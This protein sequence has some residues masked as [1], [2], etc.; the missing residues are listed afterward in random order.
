MVNTTTIYLPEGEHCQFTK[1][2]ELSGDHFAAVNQ[3]YY[4]NGLE[5]YAIYRK[6][7]KHLGLSRMDGWAADA[8]ILGMKSQPAVW[9][10]DYESNCGDGEYLADFTNLI[11]GVTVSIRR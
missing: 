11:N 4:N 2:V 6:D 8:M 5:A 7:E 10:L 9:R 1:A 3:L